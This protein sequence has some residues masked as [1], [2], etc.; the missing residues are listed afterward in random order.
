MVWWWSVVGK[1]GLVVCV[2]V[3]VRACG[4]FDKCDDVTNYKSWSVVHIILTLHFL[5]TQLLGEREKKRRD[6]Y[7][8]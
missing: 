3:C 6:T 2:C 4:A 8:K 5:L 1:I 7:I